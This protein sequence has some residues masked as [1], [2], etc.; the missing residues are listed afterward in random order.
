MGG[1]KSG[2]S[3]RRSEDSFSVS[4]AVG[5]HPQSEC[6]ERAV[7]E[8]GRHEAEG[9]CGNPGVQVESGEL[10]LAFVFLFSALI[11]SLLLFLHS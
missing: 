9:H 11:L 2:R 1:G 5:A 4:N 7:D 6:Q 8:S 10:S 3:G